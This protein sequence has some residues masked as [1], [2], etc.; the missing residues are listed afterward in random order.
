MPKV[1]LHCH[2]EGCVRPKTLV[3]LAKRN[4]VD[5]PTTD[6]TAIYDYQDMAS[7]LDVFERIGAVLCR[8]PGQAVRVLS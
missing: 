3:A 8:D 1:E 5:L 2:L 4:G 6:A 7:F